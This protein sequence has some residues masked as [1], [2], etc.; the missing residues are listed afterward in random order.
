MEKLKLQ[1]REGKNF[2]IT[3]DY[4]DQPQANKLHIPW[5]TKITKELLI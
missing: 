3:E 2:L 4:S 5:I 1:V